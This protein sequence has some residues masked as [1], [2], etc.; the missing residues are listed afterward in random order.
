MK[1]KELVDIRVTPEEQSVSPVFEIREWLNTME[2]A[3]YLKLSVGELLNLCSSG[4]V[5]YYKL[6]RRNRFLMVELRE[7]LLSQRRGPYGNS[8]K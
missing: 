3:S 1:N 7:L 6:G 2:A 8:K 5:P 4:K